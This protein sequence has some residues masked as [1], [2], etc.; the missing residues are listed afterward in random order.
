M[1][2]E[3]RSELSAAVTEAAD[4]RQSRIGQQQRLTFTVRHGKATHTL[5]LPSFCTVGDLRAPL[6]D[7]CGIDPDLQTLVLHGTVLEDDNAELGAAG[8]TEGGKLMLVGS[9]RGCAVPQRYGVRSIKQD[10]LAAACKAAGNEALGSGKLDEAIANYTEAVELSPNDHIFLSNRSAAFAKRALEGKDN[11]SASQADFR[12]AA[13]DAQ[14]CI[15]LA[16][17]FVK[18]YGRMAVALEGLGEFADA[19]AACVGGLALA[20]A[21]AG[22]LDRQAAVAQR[23]VPSEVGAGVFC[24]CAPGSS[25]TS[26]PRRCMRGGVADTDLLSRLQSCGKGIL[27]VSRTPNAGDLGESPPFTNDFAYVA[28]EPHAWE[29]LMGSV[30]SED[31]RCRWIAAKAMEHAMMHEEYFERYVVGGGVEVIAIQ[32]PTFRF[33]Y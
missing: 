25:N 29:L 6:K 9:E 8:I 5:A 17:R 22:L 23:A 26:D 21:D 18:G 13:A 33:L 31:P 24:F 11:A 15:D 4:A 3:P 19:A 27:Q 16:P 12:A 20:P 28:L 14:R 10:D 1:E 7:L 2:P 32:M 30:A